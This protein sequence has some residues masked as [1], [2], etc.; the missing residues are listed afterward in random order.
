MSSMSFIEQSQQIQRSQRT[1]SPT[2]NI[3][4]AGSDCGCNSGSHSLIA[5]SQKV[6]CGCNEGTTNTYDRTKEDSNPPVPVFQ[7]ADGCYLVFSHMEE[8]IV[9]DNPLEDKPD[10]WRPVYRRE[11]P[12]DGGTSDGG[13]FGGGGKGGGGN[14]FTTPPPP[15]DPFDHFGNSVD[16]RICATCDVVNRLYDKIADAVK[17]QNLYPDL[18]DEE[19]RLFNALYG[20]LREAFQSSLFGALGN[21]YL[22]NDVETDEAIMEEMDEMTRRLKLHGNVMDPAANVMSERGE[23]FKYILEYLNLLRKCP[24][25]VFIKLQ[26]IPI[27]TFKFESIHLGEETIYE[28][29]PPIEVKEFSK[30][31]NTRIFYSSNYGI[32]RNPPWDKDCPN[33]YSIVRWQDGIFGKNWSKLVSDLIF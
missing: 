5:Q 28:Q 4:Q 14:P 7:T 1:Q 10:Y 25:A 2:A 22:S 11:C 33:G 31:G 12:K 32:A 13:S 24:S 16:R 19:R 27:V 17:G 26:R 15:N 20:L 8:V 23:M 29:D 21:G 9:P 6:G 3:L 18:T 30:D